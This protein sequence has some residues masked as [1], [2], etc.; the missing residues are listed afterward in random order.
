MKICR[1]SQYAG[2]LIL[3]ALLASPARAQRAT[4][5]VQWRA[6]P[7]PERVA[8]G[9]SLWLRLEATIAEGWKVYALDSPPP[10]R[11]VRVRLDTL[12]DLRQAGSPRQQTPLESYDPFFEKVVRYFLNRAVLAVPLVVTPDATPG[13]RTLRAR[14]AFMTCN[15]RVCLPPTEV[16]VEATVQIDPQATSKTAPPRF[17]PA[18]PPIEPEAAPPTSDETPALTDAAAQDLVRARSGGLWG[19]L[20]LAV[21][22][23][24]AALLTPCVFPMIPLTVSFFTRQSGSR[25]QAVRMALVY[26]LAIVV[27]FTGLGVLTALLVGA[28]GAQTIAANPWVNLFIGLVFI[29]FALSLLGLY[30]LRLP[31]GLVNYFN[32]QSQTHGGYLGVLFMG[33]T[34]TLVSFSCTAP[35]VGGL[36]A[37]TALGEWGYP[38]LGM[39]AFSLTFATPFVLFALF[40][41]ALE[42]LP[43]SGAWMQTIKVVLGFVEL[44]AA[45]KFLSNADLVWGWGLLS[46]PLVI[47]LVSVLFFLTG[48]YLIGKLRLP[49]EPPVE[50]VGVGRLLVAVLF[51]GLS[52]YMLPGLLGA[53]LGNLDAYLPPR[54]ATDV[55]LVAL[56]QG[57]GNGEN[58]AEMSWHEDPDAAFAEAQATGRPVFIDFTG[59]TCTNCRQMEATVFPHPEVARRLQS[60]FVRLRLY[61]DDA[62]V[63]PEWQRYQLQ[64]TGTVALPTYAIVAPEGGPLL[65]RH[66]GMAS[67]E[68]FLAFLEEGSRAFQQRLAHQQRAQTAEPTAALR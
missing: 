28:S 19:F 66:T 25:A 34:L 14:V 9:D 46:R 42:A 45:L 5:I 7:Q 18:V 65:A 2:L 47:A 67:V 17:E 35:F 63:G 20:L 40:P 62:S 59:Y 49:H 64:L 23:G 1:R 31:S 15:D 16:P 11:G 36:L 48:L 51:F 27:T 41:R 56:L 55:G 60:D 68:E 52:L 3:L 50:T 44:A 57:S 58:G 29:L 43:R 22:A 53:P 33:L 4:E 38:V 24:L 21:G 12:P 8:P 61:T 39:V 32:R 10:T 6:H 37:A 26:G 30:E 54:R 13:T